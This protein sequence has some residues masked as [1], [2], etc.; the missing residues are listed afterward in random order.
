MSYNILIISNSLSGGGA[1]RVANLLANLL[2]FKHKCVSLVTIKN[3]ASDFV[4][5]NC[6]VISLNHKRTRNPIRVLVTILKYQYLIVKSKPT[7]IIA[8]CELAELLNSIIITRANLIVIEHSSLPWNFM[9][10]LGRK[11]RSNLQRRKTVWVSVSS[12]SE[13]WPGSINPNY[14]IPNPLTHFTLPEIAQ[15]PDN[16]IKRLVYVGRLAEEKNPQT[17]LD[18]A[19]ETALPVLFIGSG[20][21]EPDLRSSANSN[22]VEADFL[23]YR[24]QPWEFLK[25]GD[26]LIVPSLWEGDGLVVAEAI[27]LNIPTLL[28]D[29]VD[30]RRFQLPE[31]F[32][33][34]DTFACCNIVKDNMKSIRAL[35]LPK[36]IRESI[37]LGRSNSV[38]LGLWNEC[39]QQ[40]HLMNDS[41]TQA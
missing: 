22:D 29:N 3:S 30:L 31:G 17:V 26:L 32:Y 38:V 1:E 9:P 4:R 39:L 25:S 14:I 2:H 20:S 23:G 40:T 19:I 28:R 27:Q 6:N 5:P 15:S 16:E 24:K 13:I 12:K 10:K 36:N 35:L 21:L 11:V 7:H 41:K 33:F 34:A 37:I 8:N 18:V